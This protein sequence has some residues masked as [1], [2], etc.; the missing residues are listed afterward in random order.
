MPSGKNAYHPGWKPLQ[1]SASDRIPGWAPSPCRLPGP[2]PSPRTTTSG[3]GDSGIGDSGVDDDST[4]APPGKKWS[5]DTLTLKVKTAAG[6]LY[7]T[8]FLDNGSGKKRSYGHKDFTASTL[9]MLLSDARVGT[10]RSWRNLD[11]PA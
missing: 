4:L 6:N 5:Y 11:R 8:R 3:F 7:I 10:T 2:I 1:G 9:E